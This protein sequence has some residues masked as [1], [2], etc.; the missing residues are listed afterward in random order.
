M[1]CIMKMGRLKKNEN[2]RMIKNI[3][4]GP[5]IIEI[6]QKKKNEPMMNEYKIELGKLMINMMES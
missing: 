6:E 3:E 2:E 1:S 5:T 4:N